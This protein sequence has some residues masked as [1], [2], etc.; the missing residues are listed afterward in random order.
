MEGFFA[1]F[2][3]GN[4]APQPQREILYYTLNEGAWKTTE[5]WPPMHVSPDTLYFAEGNT[6]LASMPQSQQAFDSYT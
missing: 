1:P 3:K 4:T 2:L 5:V 6:L